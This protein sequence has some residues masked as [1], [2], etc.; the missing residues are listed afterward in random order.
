MKKFV[1]PYYQGQ[2]KVNYTFDPEEGQIKKIQVGGWEPEFDS[3]ERAWEEIRLDLSKSRERILAGQAS[4]LEYFMKL[5]M[6]DSRL[7]ATEAGFCHW[8][9]LRHLKSQENWMSLNRKNKENYA[10]ALNLKVEELDS[11]PAEDSQNGPNG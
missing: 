8:R 9:T 4:T 2:T 10:R 3:T 1:D 7:L 11:L 5:R 6:M